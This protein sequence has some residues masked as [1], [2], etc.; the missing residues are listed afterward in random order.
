MGMFLERFGNGW[1]F[2]VTPPMKFLADSLDC[3][4]SERRV[5]YWYYAN[6]PVWHKLINLIVRRMRVP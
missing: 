2:N 1:D 3:S 4:F 5:I 6:D